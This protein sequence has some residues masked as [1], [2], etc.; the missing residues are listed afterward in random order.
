[1]TTNTNAALRVVAVAGMKRHNDQHNRP[2]SAG[3]G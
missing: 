2:A 1:M 3:P